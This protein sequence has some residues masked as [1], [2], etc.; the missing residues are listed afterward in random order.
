MQHP[1]IEDSEFCEEPTSKE[2][3]PEDGGTFIES[4]RFTETGL[5]TILLSHP[6]PSSREALPPIRTFQLGQKDVNIVPPL[7]KKLPPVPDDIRIPQS[8]RP[9]ENDLTSRMPNVEPAP[10][11]VPSISVVPLT[12]GSQQA[13]SDIH[14]TM[15]VVQASTASREN[16]S[17]TDEQAANFTEQPG[18]SEQE[19]EAPE[20][21][22]EASTIA[23]PASV[24]F[25]SE[26][27]GKSKVA[28]SKPIPKQIEQKGKTP[29]KQERSTLARGAKPKTAAAK[30]AAIKNPVSKAVTNRSVR[31]ERAGQKGQTPRLKSDL[32]SISLSKDTSSI[33]ETNAD[34]INRE[35]T[36]KEESIIVSDEKF[37]QPT[38]L[39]D[40]M[41]SKTGETDNVQGLGKYLSLE[42]DLTIVSTANEDFSSTTNTDIAQDEIMPGQNF[43]MP[44]RVRG[45]AEG[46]VGCNEET[47]N[48]K[49][50]EQEISKDTTQSVTGS[51]SARLILVG[52]SSPPPERLPSPGSTA[53]ISSILDPVMP[54]VEAV[55]NQ[56]HAV[57]QKD[58]PKM[59]EKQQDRFQDT[60][61]SSDS[62]S[63]DSEV[64]LPGTRP[65]K[66]PQQFF[67]EAEI[68]HIPLEHPIS[69]FLPDTETRSRFNSAATQK[70]AMSSR[71]LSSSYGTRSDVQVQAYNPLAEA[72]KTKK[73]ERKVKKAKVAAEKA[74]AKTKG[75]K[76]LKAMKNAYGSLK[77]SQRN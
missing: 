28:S 62:F 75:L 53:S 23:A 68:S 15:A 31:S 16:Q 43:Q 7:P 71:L 56:T 4:P 57:L 6:P 3:L 52:R 8:F 37:L 49:P 66:K 36:E 14:S 30:T 35:L 61:Y 27:Q 45:Q 2:Q 33:M 25:T 41:E 64:D 67:L 11:L 76:R 9:A 5:P 73:G 74:D 18:P 60:D 51:E 32:T 58:V 29:L 38:N 46:A 12:T 20:Q 77:K 22:R 48:L 10:E 26:T 44:T 21:L 63:S 19:S 54:S 65:T 17:E 70:R 24:I 72:K 39:I 47:V 40:S 42:N 1:S 50:D 69:P 55:D 59:Q 34:K 13:G